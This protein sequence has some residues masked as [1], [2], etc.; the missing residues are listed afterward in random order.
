MEPAIMSWLRLASDRDGE[1]ERR[2]AIKAEG[3]GFSI[4]QRLCCP[5]QQFSVLRTFLA[6]VNVYTFFPLIKN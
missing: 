2:A 3:P 1:K 5:W 4:C 6:L